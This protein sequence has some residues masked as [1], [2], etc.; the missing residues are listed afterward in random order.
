MLI[1]EK[2]KPCLQTLQQHDLSADLRRGAERQFS[3]LLM[4]LVD[5]KIRHGLGGSE[6]L[7]QLAKTV[8]KPGLHL[9]GSAAILLDHFRYRLAHVAMRSGQW[10]LAHELLEPVVQGRSSLRLALIYQAVC[11]SKLENSRLEPGNLY[12][13]VRALTT[14]LELDGPG[15]LDLA[16]QDPVTNMGELF[17]LLQ[18]ADSHVIDG[19]YDSDQG[20]PI[21]RGLTA[22]LTVLLVPADGEPVEQTTGEWLALQQ[23]RELEQEGWLV[24]DSAAP[25][26]EQGRGSA[27]KHPRGEPNKPQLQAILQVLAQAAPVPLSLARIKALLRSEAGPDLI[28]QPR[29]NKDHQ[30]EALDSIPVERAPRAHLVAGERPVIDN[31]D[32]RWSLIPPYAVIKRDSRRTLHQSLP[33]P[34]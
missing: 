2:L 6:E 16:V 15:P 21:K 19:L 11:M 7:E 32:R 29:A 31:T 18:D 12:E 9:H 17:L 27:V 24:V 13:L 8:L 28:G 5:S 23:L 25:F 30:T 14:P 3:K 22:G 10:S 1:L 4:Q 26:G 34:Q 33:K 20:D